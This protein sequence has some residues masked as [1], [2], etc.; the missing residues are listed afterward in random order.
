M[1]R[2]VSIII[3]IF[4]FLPALSQEIAPLRY[5]QVHGLVFDNENTP[6]RYVNIISKGLRT[7]TETDDRGIF[8]IISYPGDTLI[9]S[10]IGYQ[11]TFTRIPTGVD[12]P[13]FTVDII[14]NIDTIDIGSVLVLPWRTYEEFKRAVVEYVSPMEIEISNMEKNLALIE[15]QINQDANITPEAGHRYAMQQEAERIM[16][17]NQTPVNNLFN[18][19]AWAKFIDGLKNGLL[20]NKESKKKK[21]R[22]NNT[23]YD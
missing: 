9:F 21:D 5:I 1:N 16:T 18:P 10:S 6:V 7:G 4:L 23:D 13:V 17:R 14:M 15:S 3:F 22:D 11:P 2:L 20:K 12:S 8:S 19:F